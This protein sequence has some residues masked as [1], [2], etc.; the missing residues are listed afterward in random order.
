MPHRSKETHH[1]LSPAI[2]SNSSVRPSSQ[3]LLA[4]KQGSHHRSFFSQICKPLG[5]AGLPSQ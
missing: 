5:M 2:P 3:V 4:L 1:P